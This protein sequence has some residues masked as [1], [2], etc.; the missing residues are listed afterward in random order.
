MSIYKFCLNR[1][2]RNSGVD[3]AAQIHVIHQ[4]TIMNF[5]PSPALNVDQQLN[6]FR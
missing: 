3:I 4:Y 6:L 2:C 1:I 5:V